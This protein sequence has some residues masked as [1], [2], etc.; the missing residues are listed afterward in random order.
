MDVDFFYIILDQDQEEE[1]NKTEIKKILVEKPI[2]IFILTQKV[3][4][5]S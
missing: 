4:I 2:L 3:E 1:Q 5:E